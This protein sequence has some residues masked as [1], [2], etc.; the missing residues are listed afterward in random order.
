MIRTKKFMIIF[1][2]VTLSCMTVFASIGYATLTGNLTISGTTQ[3]NEAAAIYIKEVSVTSKSNTTNNPQVNK[4]GYLVIQHG[5]YQLNKQNNFNSGGGSVTLEIT[6]RNNS[7]VDQ[8]FLG[9]SSNPAWTNSHKVTFSGI[10]VGTLI[11]HRGTV[12]FTM[13]IQNTYRS[14]MNMKGAE[15]ILNFS[16]NFDESFTEKVTGDI[17]STF[18]SVLRGD[19]IDGNGT[20]ITFKGKY[21][22]AEDIVQTLMDNMEGVDTGGYIA[23]IG[24]FSQD[25]KDLVN[26]VFGG[27]A[28]LQ[29]GNQYYSVSMLIKNQEIN[30]DRQSDM[31]LYVTADQLTIG[32]GGW[33]NGAYRNL[34]I[35]PV[36]GLVFINNGHG[37]YTYCDHIFAGEAPV[38]NKGGAFG[39]NCTGNF[40]TN[41]WNSTDYPD[42]KDES[43]GNITADYI[44]TN[45]ELD[46]AYQRY[47]RENP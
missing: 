45:G 16:P 18:Q 7:G 39:E 44:S 2:C 3:W 43:G 5:D 31:V 37:E 34:H 36:Y 20:G 32:G 11:V 27:S 22:E 29:I 21:V 13:T 38:C 1:I 25:Q 40:N 9:H 47:I 33:S 26:A 28:T 24:D 41:L 17:A 10:K 14:A 15:S 35:V 12:T 46:E 4:A 30:N 6:V 42:L 19:G 8:Y 23:N